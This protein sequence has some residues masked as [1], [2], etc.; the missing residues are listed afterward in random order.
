M[1]T[2]NHGSNKMNSN[3]QIDLSR[4]EIGFFEPEM[5]F[6]YLDNIITESVENQNESARLNVMFDQ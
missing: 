3:D 6:D 2:S 1:A 5:N 4:Y